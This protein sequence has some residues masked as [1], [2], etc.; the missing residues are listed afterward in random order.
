MARQDAEDLPASRGTSS[1]HERRR[2]DVAG[3]T[4]VADD[5]RVARTKAHVLAVAGD[6]IAE[7]GRGGFTVDAVAKRSG[8]ARTTIYRHWPEIGDLLYDTFRSMGHAVP[9]ADTGSVR[10]DLLA[11]YGALADG[12]ETSCIGRSMPTLLDI[13]RRDESLQPLHRAFI[14]ERRRPSLDAI[15]R[16]VERGE[17]PADVDG[18]LLVD[19]IAGPVFYRHLVAQDPYSRKDVEH[20]IDDTLAGELPRCRGRQRR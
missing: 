2:Q 14:A 18:E 5:P 8:V 6:L 15:R 19:R 4:D 11:L 1:R 7:E 9:A 17:L 10:G 16:G 20:L 3:A 12:L 13:S